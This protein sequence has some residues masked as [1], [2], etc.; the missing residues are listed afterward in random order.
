MKL[1]ISKNYYSLTKFCDV[2]LDRSSSSGSSSLLSSRLAAAP[3]APG[4]ASTRPPYHFRELPP[5]QAKPKFQRHPD[6]SKF[7]VAFQT[8]LPLHMVELIVGNF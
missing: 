4:G 6:I 8:M 3:M 2:L 5:L 7:T 1:T